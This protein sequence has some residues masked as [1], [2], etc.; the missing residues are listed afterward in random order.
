MPNDEFIRQML[1]RAAELAVG[2]SAVR[3]QG[4]PG[5]PGKARGALKRLRLEAFVVT[6]E[7]AFHA[8]LDRT[9][10]VLKNKLPRRA[11]H[12]GTAR[13]ILNLYLRDVLYNGY[14]CEHFSFNRVEQWLELPLDS[15]TAKGIK[16]DMPG[17]SLPR[18]TTIKRLAHR[19]SNRFQ[20]AARQIAQKKRIARVHLDLWY[21]RNR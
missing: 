16:R 5:V 17:L 3:N 10:F 4:A 2:P 7:Q 13:K 15:F 20:E 21:W 19:N 6:S 12:W 1:S 14:L 18:C 8:K 11:R 9:T